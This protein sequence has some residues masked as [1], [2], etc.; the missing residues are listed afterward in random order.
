MDLV[1]VTDGVRAVMGDEF[2]GNRVIGEG[3]WACEGGDERVRT[4]G[5]L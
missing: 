1:I 4:G 5:D 2:T 3:Q